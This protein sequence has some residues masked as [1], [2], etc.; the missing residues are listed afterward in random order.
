MPDKT[1]NLFVYGTLMNPS[2][3]RAVL[4]RRMV[5]VAS[6][7]DGGEAFLARNAVLEG[8]K[9]VS[10]DSTYLYAV[11]DPHGRIRGYIIGPLPVECLKMLRHY[12]GRN[13][14]RRRVRVQTSECLEKALAF[15]GNLKQLEH[16]FGYAF[17]D[18]L[19]QE[20]LLRQKID[21]ILQETQR[22]QL[23]SEDPVSLRAM[24][25]LHGSTIRDLV[26][27]HF[28]AGGVSDYVIRHSIMDTPLRD[29]PRTLQEGEARHLAPN[30]LTM[31]IRQVIFNQIEE[32]IRKD[33]RYEL[34]HMRF[35]TRYYE[36]T[37]SSVVA[38]RILNEIGPML[39][40]LAADAMTDLAVSKSHLIDYVRW[41]VVAAD[42]I[43]DPRAAR[44]EMDYV[45]THTAGGAIPLG[46][47]LEF[48]NI[49]HGVIRDP[50]AKTIRDETY[51]GFLYFTDYALDVLTWKLGGHVDDHHEKAS[52]RRR[53]GFFEIA[54][55]S[56]SV[57]ANLSKPVTDDPW[58]LNQFIHEAR[59]F[60]D[61]APHSLHISLQLRSQHRPG[62]DR[63]L[64][65]R[66]MKCLFAIAG[67]PVR[68][69]EGRVR[70]GRLVSDEIYREDPTPQM[71]FSEISKRHSSEEGQ[72]DAPFGA[73]G[74]GGLYVQQFKFLRLSPDLDYEPIVMGLKGLQLSLRPGSFLLPAQ[75]KAS[76]RHRRLFDELQAWARDAR[77]IDNDELE[78]FLQHIYD[79]LTTEHRGKPAHS[80]AYIAWSLSQLR[81]MVGKFNALFKERAA[82]PEP[83]SKR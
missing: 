81:R 61:I 19:K 71:L 56:L 41:A 75:Y 18:P 46:A 11:P 14:A 17:H 64:P 13:Y 51:D 68:T 10:P 74:R 69:P 21:R 42:A 33:F 82:P 20:I 31:V 23:H 78:P 12:E 4:G 22:E 57:E 48:S 27:Q 26:R 37:V 73:R 47:E 43:Y 28:D 5:T 2:V 50:L 7:A 52:R 32:Q 1:F 54:L 58:L 6:D 72:A 36:R 45:R 77:P 25:E 83:P 76:A 49:G 80:G 79:G 8:Y 44:R 35:S 66:V 67:D 15:V 63:L 55:G 38:L 53:R 9:K 70:I 39:N 3:L 30:Y 29:F 62:K 59:R 34:D 65:L 16:S 40:V 60:Y 24:A